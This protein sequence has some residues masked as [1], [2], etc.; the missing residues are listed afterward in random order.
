M[1]DF[2]WENG[3]APSLNASNMQLITDAINAN[4]AK[5]KDIESEVTE[6]VIEH[7]GSIVVPNPE[8]EAT[9][10]LSK[11][12]INQEVFEIKGGGDSG[13]DISYEDYMALVAA[14]EDEENK[15][16]FVPDAPIGI[17]VA[18]EFEKV[19]E[20]INYIKHDVQE[21]EDKK[22]ENTTLTDVFDATKSYSAGDYFIS[23][24]QLFKVKVACS[25]ITPPNSTYY[26]SISVMNELKASLNDLVAEKVT[27]TITSDSMGLIPNKNGYCPVS[28]VPLLKSDNLYPFVTAIGHNNTAYYLYVYGW[29]TAGNKIPSGTQMEFEILYAKV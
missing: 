13:E 11:V 21:I 9:D 10:T 25:G 27:I 5:I 17:P 6:I 28:V 23:N 19:Y 26:D 18:E 3:Q 14:D 24:N 12:K 15:N 2:K 4:E 29:A 22:A 16:Y 8:E 20:E 1:L 7:G